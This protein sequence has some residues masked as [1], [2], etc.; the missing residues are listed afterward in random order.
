ALASG[1]SHNVIKEV[2][3]LD[4]LARFFSVVVSVQDVGRNKPA[5]DVFLLAADRLGIPPAEC[6]VIEDSIVGVQAAKAAGMD[7]IAITNSVPREQ[8]NE[9]TYVVD[10]YD[11]IAALLLPEQGAAK[12]AERAEVTR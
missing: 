2:L 4:G 7:V 8:L 12:A 6:M 9:A 5:P 11:E 3:A 1:S 10:G